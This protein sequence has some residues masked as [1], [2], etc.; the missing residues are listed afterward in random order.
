ME[1]LSRWNHPLLGHVSPVDFIAT[2]ERIGMIKLLTEW[3]LYTA[4]HQAVSWKNEGGPAIHMAVNI[5]PSHFLDID[6]V[7][8]IKRIIDETKMTVSELELEVTENVVQTDPRNISTFRDLK[9]FGVDLAIDD[10]GTGYSSIASLKHLNVDYLKIDKCFID[11]MLVDDKALIL[12]DSM[13]KMGH[14]LGY[15]IIAEGVET[16]DQLCILNEL[17]CEM[18]QGYLFSKPVKADQIPALLKHRFEL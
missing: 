13:I 9:D 16:R 3:V 7:S 12:V 17:G 2:A 14:K 18:V 6:I 15:E 1:A 10:F 5:S 4:C 8:L 11:D